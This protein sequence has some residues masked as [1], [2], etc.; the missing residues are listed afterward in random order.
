MIAC[1]DALRLELVAT[2]MTSRL[3]DET[4]LLLVAQQHRTKNFAFFL[5]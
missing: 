4:Y 1:L 5:I 2:T 3:D